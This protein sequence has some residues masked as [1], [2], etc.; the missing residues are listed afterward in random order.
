[1]AATILGLSTLSFGTPTISG[2]VVNSASFAES[3]NIAEVMDEDGDY[4]AASISGK[5]ITGNISAIDAGGTFS[6]GFSLVVAGAPTGVYCITEI[7]TTRTADGFR[8]KDITLQSWAGITSV[9]SGNMV[10][11]GAGSTEAN[12]VY[13]LIGEKNGKP[14]YAKGGDDDPAIEWVGGE[15]RII[16]TLVDHNLVHYTSGSNVATP[17]LASWVVEEGFAPV[18]TVTAQMTTI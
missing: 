17:N 13:L 12:G 7:T 18:P 14:L 10:V 15:W 3:V 16:D 2:L 11:A 1:M 6:T 4:V 8:A 9:P 5:R